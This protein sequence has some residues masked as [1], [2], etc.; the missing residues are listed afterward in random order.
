MSAP[1]GYR[2]VVVGAKSHTR[3]TYFQTEADASAEA[4]RLNEEAGSTMYAIEY[5]A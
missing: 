4:D 5:L 1:A 3:Y 2:W